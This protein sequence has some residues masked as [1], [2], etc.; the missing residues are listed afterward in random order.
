MTTTELLAKVRELVQQSTDFKNRWEYDVPNET[1]H[2]DRTHVS[3]SLLKSIRKSPAAFLG[4]FGGKW[5][6]KDSDAMQFGRA[7][8][9]AVLEGSDVFF[10]QYKVMPDFGDLRFK[11]NKANKTAWLLKLQQEAPLAI[12]VPKADFEAMQGV[13]ESIISH[14]DAF[15][16]LKNSAREV[17]GYYLCPSTGI[18]CRVRPDILSNDLSFL[19]D[20][21]TTN[22]CT[23]HRFADKVAK[24]GWDFSLCMYASGVEAIS[25]LMPKEMAFIAV[26]P[27]PQI[28]RA[29]V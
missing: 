17:S 26:E 27:E 8:H 4:N 6:K 10:R 15:N 3:S 21:K 18:R 1:Y 19:V 5:P 16:L 28:G 9:C 14:A 11:E 24:M 22:D 29:H 25:G 7:A 2:E 23:I 13:V 20:F 12:P